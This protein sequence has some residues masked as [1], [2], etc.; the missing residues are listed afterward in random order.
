MG[1]NTPVLFLND[2]TSQ[3]AADR[4]L[5]E[6]IAQAMSSVRIG[7][8]HNGLHKIDVPAGNYANAV[9]ILAPQHSNESWLLHLHGNLMVRS[10]RAPGARYDNPEEQLRAAAACLGFDLVRVS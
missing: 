10:C 7:G 4:D 2:A 8:S 9:S 1:Y 3:I 5:G 6:K